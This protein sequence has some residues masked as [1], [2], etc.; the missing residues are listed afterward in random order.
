MPTRLIDART[1]QNASYANSIAI[2]VTTT[3]QLVGQIAFATDGLGTNPRVRLAAAAG[4]Q[5]NTAVAGSTVTLMLVRGTQ[6][7]DTPIYSARHMPRTGPQPQSPDP[8]TLSIS[9]ADFR[10]PIPANRR[11]VYSLF[12]TSDTPGFVRTGPE[13]F[14][15]VLYSD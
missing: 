5:N 15:G 4:V 3:P 12:I 8:Q 9:A 2:P 1:S 13:N 7:T 10:P 14:D 11:L 6:P